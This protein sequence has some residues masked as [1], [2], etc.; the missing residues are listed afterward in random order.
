M[1]EVKRKK[2][3]KKYAEKKKSIEEFNSAKDPME[4]LEIHRIQS[5]QRIQLTELGIDVTTKTKRCLRD[6]GL[7]RNQL[8]NELIMVNFQEL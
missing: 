5:L 6:F 4:R 1:Q 2:L 7:C 3:V 8:N